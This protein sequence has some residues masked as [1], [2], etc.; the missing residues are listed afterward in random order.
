MAEP[1]V[2][3]INRVADA[4]GGIARPAQIRRVA[5]AEHDA[6]ILGAKA[7][8][9][10]ERL[11]ILAQRELT[12][13]EQ[14]GVLRRIQQDGIE[15]AS[16]EA[17]LVKAIPLVEEHAA[18][19]KMEEDWIRHFFDR[20][21]LISNDEMREIW[22]RILAGEANCP[23]SFSKRNLS[24]IFNI[25]MI[26]AQLFAELMIYRWKIDDSSIIVAKDNRFNRYSQ[27]LNFDAILILE[28]AGLIRYDYDGLFGGS[29]QISGRGKKLIYNGAL[30]DLPENIVSIRVG[31]V[32][33][34]KS[35]QEISKVCEAI[36]NRIYMVDCYKI[37]RKSGIEIDDHNVSEQFCLEISK[38]SEYV[39]GSVD[40]DESSEDHRPD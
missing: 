10:I 3:L 35:G 6:K 8:I 1:A 36:G 5:A 37:F 38:M 19:D 27:K 18:P 30:I 25:D 16:I 14:R 31:C 29:Y 21:R 4:I 32:L 20:A 23:G 24:I 34:T 17:V 9:E 33:L 2:V 40:K 12:E 28:Q 39:D 11:R 7:D 26:T 22:A 13:F 15:Q